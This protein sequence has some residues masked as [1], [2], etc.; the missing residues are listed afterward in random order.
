MNEK[1]DALMLLSGNPVLRIF[2]VLAVFLAYPFA[3]MALPLGQN[4]SGLAAG[5]LEEAPSRGRFL[6]ASRELVEPTF[7]RRVVLLLDHDERRGGIGLIIN[8]PSRMPLAQIVPGF[9]QFATR[10]D[11]I[12]S[13]GPVERNRLFMLIRADVRPPGTEQVL[14][15]TYG[16]STLR[17]LRD[18]IASG[19]AES[20]EFVVYAGYAGWAPGQLEAEIGRGDW[21]VAP[22]RS[23]H[24]FDTDA[25]EVW[26][27][28]IRLHG[29]K[30]VEGPRPASGLA[31]AMPHLRA[32]HEARV[33]ALQEEAVP[34]GGE[35]PG[36]RRAPFRRACDAPA[37]AE[38]RTIQGL[39]LSKSLS[40]SGPVTM[41]Q[42]Q[43]PSRASLLP[44]A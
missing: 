33:A 25:A 13:G 30:W 21:H 11:Y 43:S 8:R 35:R 1:G 14:G 24:V 44:G 18:L 40:L 28:L 15:D 23:E 2:A 3:P 37:E 31:D 5:T 26:P 4:P 32:V 27:K 29:G 41:L 22:G 34:Q 20:A 7:A 12:R 9:E 19:K 36:R 42:Y 17:P 38:G 39:K 6:I 16:S 10:E